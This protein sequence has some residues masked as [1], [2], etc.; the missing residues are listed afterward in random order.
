MPDFDVFLSFT[1][2]DVDAVDPIERALRDNGLRVCRDSECIPEFDGITEELVPG[3]ASAK[4]LAAYSWKRY[5]TRP[6]C[7][8]E[9]TSAII[10]AQRDGD[11]RRRVLVVNPERNSDHIAPVFLEDARYFETPAGAA[12]LDRL[13]RRVRARVDAVTGPLGGAQAGDEA[14]RAARPVRPPGGV[15]GPVP[16]RWGV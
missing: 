12:E 8:W 11:P 2:S 9:L 3:L 10:A 16:Q 15:L 5:P 6:A 4:V 1:W 14:A 13:A 7:Q